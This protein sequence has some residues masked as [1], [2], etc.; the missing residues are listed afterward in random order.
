MKLKSLLAIAG[1]LLGASGL[2]AQN[3]NIP[4]IR[5]APFVAVNTITTTD[6]KGT[7]PAVGKVARN[8]AGSTYVEIWRTDTNQLT[9]ILI[10]DVPGKRSIKL[11]VEKKWYAVDEDP[12]LTARDLPPGTTAQQIDQ[13]QNTKPIHME[14]N[15]LTRDI[16]PLG[17]KE[18]EGIMTLGSMETAH[19]SGLGPD[20]RDYTTENWFSPE[21]QIMLLH[22]T[23][24]SLKGSEM[25]SSLSHVQRVEPDPALF[26]IPADYQRDPLNA[27][28]AAAGQGAPK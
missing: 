14:A 24:D 1:L 23:H 8:S 25:V 26:Q 21:L 18:I 10:L 28:A 20:A 3:M 12:T 9:E 22:V 13:P 27:Q 4:Q 2:H 7:H 11:E 17:K 19:K 6:S 16:L 15:G 5:N